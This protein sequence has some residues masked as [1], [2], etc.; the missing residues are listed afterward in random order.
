MPRHPR[1]SRLRTAAM[2]PASAALALGM[3]FANPVLAA[4]PVPTTQVTLDFEQLSGYTRLAGQADSQVAGVRYGGDAVGF[5]DHD[6]PQGAGGLDIGNFGRAP[7]PVGVLGFFGETARTRG[8]IVNVG[9]G[10]AGEVRLAYSTIKN[11]AWIEIW[12]GLDGSGV[13]LAKS[14]SGALRALGSDEQPFK[15]AFGDEEYGA[16]NRWAEMTL[17]FE[18]TGRSLV[19]SGSL[20]PPAQGSGGL[21][22]GDVLFD[23]IVLSVVPEAPSTALLLA[24][25]G[26]LGLYGRRRR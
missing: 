13:L 20:L 15:G 4:V 16:Y 7:S 3:W 14:P 26:L 9:S 12:S 23:N 19:L 8:A 18:G 5:V 17:G 22:F 21:S 25:L 10:F 6:S 11:P 1:Q 24:G 2:G